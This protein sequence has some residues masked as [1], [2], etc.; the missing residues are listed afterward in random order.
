MDQSSSFP[1]SPPYRATPVRA[2]PTAGTAAQRAEF[3]LACAVV[4]FAPMNFVRLPNFYFT[5]SDAFACLCLGF[6]ILNRLLPL[7]P[8]GPGTAYWLFGLTLM[9]GALLGSSL[10]ASV[11]DR[12]L[13]LSIQY[14]FAYLLLPLVL[15]GRP[16]KQTTIL[17]K[18]FVAS[19]ILMI[20]HGIYVIDILKETNTTFVS[21]SGRLMGFVERDNECGGLIALTVPMILAMTSMR[22][23]HPLITLAILPL[24][25]YGIMLT[26]SN[27]A[28]Y[29]MLY[30]LGVF[31]LATI[32]PQR[33]AIGVAA[34]M[35]MVSG[36]NT[37]V[38]RDNL[39]A[40]FQKRVLTGLES[41]DLSEA[42]TFDDRMRMIQE[43]SGFAGDVVLVGYGA[44]QYREISAFHAPVHNLYLLMWNEGGLIALGG[45]LL[46]LT[47]G[48]IALATPLRYRG[49]REVFVGGF[50]TLSLFAVLIN[51]V[52]HVYGRFWAVPVLLSIA[53]A[54][55]FLN[56]GPIR[57]RKRARRARA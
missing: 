16:W 51:A 36:L 54:V 47:G 56:E 26:G 45:F 14:L 1:G 30:G 49:S 20:L 35:L 5:A 48:F 19:I 17:M 42:G 46:M 12:G 41:G 15:L 7:K 31:F 44:D 27:T 40:T 57:Q 13:I 6:M 24:I 38:I 39:P 23:L 10:L 53:P 34:V 32:T 25:T 8:L 28:L 37:P 50:A 11:V 52:P 4:F 9:V 29:A 22:T 21:G 55:T 43:A 33:A 18:V 2:A 3:A